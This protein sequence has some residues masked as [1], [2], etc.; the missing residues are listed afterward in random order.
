MPNATRRKRTFLQSLQAEQPWC[1]YCGMTT[2]GDTVDH[3]PPIA[4]FELRDR[5]KGLE[6][7]ACHACNQG[8]KGIDQVMSLICRAYPDAKTDAAKAELRKLMRAVS[9]NHP[10]AFMELQPSREQVER[11]RRLDNAPADAAGVFNL[12]GPNV[13]DATLRFGAKAALALHYQRTKRILPASGAVFVRC[14]TNYDLFKDEIPPELL[15]AVGEPSTLKQG[16]KSVGDQFGFAGGPAKDGTL[17]F[18]TFRVTLSYALVTAED[19][20]DLADAP[21]DLVLRPG[22]LKPAK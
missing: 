2:L 12:R 14:F 3:M 20:S 15:A 5:P 1:V 22:C 4:M 6:F 19:P 18:I 10:D 11:A 21:A 17:H 7:L 16:A 9:N 13:M 8:S